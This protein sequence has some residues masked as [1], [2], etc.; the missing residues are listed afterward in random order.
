MKLYLT[1][2]TALLLLN[3]VTGF[4]DLYYGNEAADCFSGSNERHKQEHC[5]SNKRDKSDK[6]VDLSI[7]ETNKRIKANNI[8]PFNGKEDA[9]ETSGDVYSKRFLAAQKEWKKYRDQLCLA[10]A[11][12]IDEDAYD[13]QSYIDQCTINL[14]KRHIDEINMMGLPPAS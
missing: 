14:N 2:I 11:T 4:A 8:G 12:E 1:T 5:L 10:V 7:N 13:Y 9:K 6:E 3:P